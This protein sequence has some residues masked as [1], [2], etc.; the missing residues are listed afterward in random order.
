MT[1]N[2]SLSPGLLSKEE[3]P[4]CVI[5]EY[6]RL[7]KFIHGAEAEE[8]RERFEA[9]AADFDKDEES[10]IV[11][12]IWFILDDVDARDSCA[13]LETKPAAGLLSSPASPLDKMVERAREAV[14]V[15]RDATREGRLIG[16]RQ[17]DPLIAAIHD[18]LD[19][20]QAEIERVR[21]E[22]S[23]PARPPLEGLI[24][25]YRDIVGMSPNGWLIRD[26][27]DE[28]EAALAE[29][30]SAPPATLPPL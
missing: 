27:A 13:F 30:S 14:G 5:G 23:S 1:D 2:D 24:A 18:A 3:Q 28:L 16:F 8:L 12:D 10:S 19:S 22:V 21:A 26:F 4:K 20:Q 7:H 9:M 17:R 15:F 25:K 11:R 29:V 6:C